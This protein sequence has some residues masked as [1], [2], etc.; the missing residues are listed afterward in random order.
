LN[1]CILEYISLKM[2]SDT[3]FEKINDQYSYGQ[4]A[5]F[6]VII[7]NSNSYINATKLCNQNGK[8][9]DNWLRNDGNKELINEVNEYISAPHIRGAEAIIELKGGDPLV[10][11]S[12]VHP[13]LIPHISSCFNCCLDSS[14]LAINSLC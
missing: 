5:D 10:R 8:R 7:M 3:I 11:G 9:F 1:I 14:L 2:I 4:Y 12:Y 13:L 6:K